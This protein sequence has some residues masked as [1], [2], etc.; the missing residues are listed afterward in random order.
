MSIGLSKMT[1]DAE[2]LL[3]QCQL[4]PALELLK[5]ARS[6]TKISFRRLFITFNIGVVYWDKVGDGFSARDEFLAAANAQDPDLD[7]P[8]ARVLR[9]NALEN[10][11]LSALSFDEFDDFSG[12]L[13]ALAPEMPVI[14]GL[15][16]VIHEMRDHGSP[17]SSA[18]F[19]LASCNY[20]RNNPSQDRGR[21]GVAKS[22]YH[23]LLATRKQQ[24][25][26]RDDWRLA[27]FEYCALA[28]RMANDC[29]NL[30]GGDGDAH[31]PEEFLPMLADAIPYMDEYLAV[32]TG[33]TGMQKVRDDMQSILDNTRRRWATI[34]RDQP[35]WKGSFPV[36]D[37]PVIYRCRR[38]NKP[39]PNVAH[40]CPACGNPSPLAALYPSICVAAILAGSA[41]WHFAAAQ[42][43]W[44]RALW[45]VGTAV[46]IFEVVGP[47]MF[48]VWLRR[49]KKDS[50]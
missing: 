17:W 44:V 1:D 4:L 6:I 49:F 19:Y 45:A 30:R 13:R 9:A 24:R 15:P 50:D 34:T 40:A 47:I 36:S 5:Q 41:A 42:P 29:Q 32:F 16:P 2:R 37:A 39:I 21:Y 12:K 48:Q 26:S 46:F 20:N 7:H 22:T 11:M 8:S 28:M 33:D 25:L 10:L 18:L 38:C 23:L 35:N 14:S 43:L 31:S 3:D 27:V